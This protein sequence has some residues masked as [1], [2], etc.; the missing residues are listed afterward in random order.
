MSNPIVQFLQGQVGKSMTES[1]SPLARWLNGTFRE[2]KEGE[3]TVDFTIRE[4]MT[5]P[6]GITHGGAVSAMLDEIIGI[7]VYSLHN[8]APYATVNLNVDFLASSRPGETV[9]V[10]AKVIRKGRNIAHAE[11]HMYNAAGKLLA[12]A[13]SNLL[14]TQ[15]KTGG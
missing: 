3:L 12:K 8:E 15:P 11:G 13:T 4:D 5:N 9:T 7:A 14:A 10:K 2:V 6:L 1:P